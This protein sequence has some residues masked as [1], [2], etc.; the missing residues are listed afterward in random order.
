MKPQA[1]ASVGESNF[2]SATRRVLLRANALFL[3]IAGSGGFV[4]DAAIGFVS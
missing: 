2:T 1:I 4:T 3:L